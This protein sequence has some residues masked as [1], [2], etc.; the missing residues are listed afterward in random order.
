MQD[1]LDLEL[2]D[3]IT[4]MRSE[5][6]PK[7]RCPFQ[8]LFDVYTEKQLQARFR[9]SKAGVKHL[10]DKIV[11]HLQYVERRG[12]PLDSMHQLLIG[13]QYLGSTDLL[14][15][16]GDCLMVSKYSAW[17]CVD[18]VVNAILTLEPEFV[19]YLDRQQ[20]ETTATYMYN[21]Y[22]IGNTFMGV[23]GTHI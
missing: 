12:N 19:Y 5:Y 22:G 9:F 8:N 16:T 11:D 23:D 14:R 6:V 4:V 13:L 10:H 15:D 18:R 20:M 7:K 1:I 21:K 3:L 2:L 17:K